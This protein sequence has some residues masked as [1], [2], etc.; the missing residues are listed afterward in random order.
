[1]QFFEEPDDLSKFLSKSFA[2][3]YTRVAEYRLGNGFPRREIFWRESLDA[4]RPDLADWRK[5]SD[6]VK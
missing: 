1:L 2:S 5:F 3:I 4:A 6:S